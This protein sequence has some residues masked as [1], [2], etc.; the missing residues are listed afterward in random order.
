[1][2]LK[3]MTEQEL[4]IW[5]ETRFQKEIQG[6]AA[7]RAEMIEH[8]QLLQDNSAGIKELLELSAGYKTFLR[9]MRGAERTAV[10]FT[11]VGIWFA[12]LWAFWVYIVKEAVK[13]SN[14]GTP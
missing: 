2:A 1:M 9:I 7:F 3:D 10:F 12:M 11:K 14:G 4:E 5:I 8:K 13:N 6:L